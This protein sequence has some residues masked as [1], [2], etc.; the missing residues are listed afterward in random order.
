MA[1]MQILIV[2]DD[3]DIRE[4][5][6]Q[7]L[8]Q[9]DYQ[10]CACR[11]AGEAMRKIEAFRPDCMIIDWMLPDMSGIELIRWLRR[12]PGL[13]HIPSLMLTARAQEVDKIA[14]LEAG[15]D[16]YMTKPMSLREMHARIKAL[17]R[18]PG[19]YS[20]DLHQLALGSL[21]LN[22]QTY[23]VFIDQTPLKLSKTEFKLLRF[24]MENP[25]KV[26]TRDHILNAVWGINA[27]VDDR[28]V[29]VHILRLRRKLKQQGLVDSI[30]TIRGAGYRFSGNP[31]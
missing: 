14:G 1:S 20:E 15:A 25:N 11:E 6:A 26:F 30:V 22:T 31:A 13:Q 12:Q 8:V 29:D 10:V 24:F 23:E 27:F 3:N 16:D 17:L 5:I 28:T 19:A 4:L 18:R 21:Q 9:A 7:S 2:E